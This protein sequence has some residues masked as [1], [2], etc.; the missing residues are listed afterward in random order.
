MT[1]VALTRP[2]MKTTIMISISEKPRGHSPRERRRVMAREW[3]L[4]EV[5][6]AD[7][8]IGAFAAFHAVGTK[9]EEVVFLATG[10]R[11]DVLVG[12]APGIGADALDVAVLPPIAHGRI[13]RPLPQGGQA[14]I[15]ARKL[16]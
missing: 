3:L 2:M 5:P 4:A 15:R 14:E 7:V 12:I 1:T 11:V 13:V 10:S 16:V 9:G 6:V 8:R